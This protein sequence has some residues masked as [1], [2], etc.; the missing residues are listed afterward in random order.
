MGA[1]GC[2]DFQGHYKF[3]GPED[4]TYVLQVYTGCRSCDTPAGVIIYAMDPEEL[5][6]WGAEDLPDLPFTNGD[7]SIPVLHPKKL[8]DKLMECMKW[9]AEE[10]LGEGMRDFGRAVYET[11]DEWRKA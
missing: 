10:A 8:H 1:C 5:G 3:S 11:F 7:A 9:M 4:I 2:G 6:L